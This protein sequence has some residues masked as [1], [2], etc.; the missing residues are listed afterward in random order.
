MY[1]MRNVE[2][3]MHSVRNGYYYNMAASME[4]ANNNAVNK[5]AA[6][7][8]ERVIYPYPGHQKSKVWEY[9]GFYKLK[10]G[11]ASKDNLDMTYAI[12]RLCTKKYANKGTV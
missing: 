10:D 3:R 9:F 8:E 4:D 1:E 2:N 11:P 6:G 7:V 12:C 5:D